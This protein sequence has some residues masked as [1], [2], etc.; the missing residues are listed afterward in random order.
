MTRN[1]QI[2]WAIRLTGR[3][4]PR[5]MHTIYTARAMAR[6]VAKVRRDHGTPATVVRATLVLPRRSRKRTA[7]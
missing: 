4:R 6:H 1:I 2:V 3:P 7:R 5:L